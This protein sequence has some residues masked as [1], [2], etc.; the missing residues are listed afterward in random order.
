MENK[1][2]LRIAKQSEDEY[3]HKKLTREIIGAAMEVY[4]TLGF[5]FLESV[6]EE[7]LAVE[8]RL[9]DIPFERQK[10]LDVCYKGEK[11]K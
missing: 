11:V 3:P 6:Y 2:K 9:R 10:S 8:F 1:D 7:A 4:S 5:G